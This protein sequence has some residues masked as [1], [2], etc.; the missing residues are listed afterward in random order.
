[1][2]QLATALLAGAALRDALRQVG[3]SESTYYRELRRSPDLRT[4]LGDG[5]GASPAA[6][7]TAPRSTPRSA[8]SG[9]T[10]GSKS[11][12]RRTTKGAP[13][14]ATAVP[15]DRAPR[16]ARRQ[17]TK[18]TTGEATAAA[19]AAAPPS[20]E[21][22]VEE[23]AAAVAAPAAEIPTADLVQAE[24]RARLSRLVRNPYSFS[25]P[26]RDRSRGRRGARAGAA[27]HLVR[28]AAPSRADW[29]PPATVLV[30]QLVVAIVVGAHP[31][32]ILLIAV[33]STALVLAIRHERRRS[34]RMDGIA[35][36]AGQQQAAP[37][38]EEG[39]ADASTS[40]DEP[41]SM[42]LRWIASTILPAGS[43]SDDHP[44]PRI[45]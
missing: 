28:G 23:P 4:A 36:T 45:H 16:P 44:N 10:P 43:R 13:V 25:I 9:D 32:V 20:P 42:D 34:P 41:R 29:M 8:S 19:R 37:D 14:A 26:A 22:I 27:R 6:D 17:R 24:P 15:Q 7:E 5:A 18:R 33:T 30:L 12:R 38:Q 21:P 3:V 1:M 31:L 40:A 39:A 35:W 2:R 11:E